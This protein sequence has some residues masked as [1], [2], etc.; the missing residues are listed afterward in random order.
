MLFAQPKTSLLHMREDSN[1]GSIEMVYQGSVNDVE[2]NSFKT[3]ATND[4]TQAQKEL[5]LKQRDDTELANQIKHELRIGE[6]PARDNTPSHSQPDI[7]SSKLTDMLNG[8]SPRTDSNGDFRVQFPSAVP[9]PL[10]RLHGS[11]VAVQP[12]LRG[13]TGASPAGP[14]TSPRT[15][16]T[17]DDHFYMTNEHLDVVGKTTYDALDMY[18]KQQISATNGKHEQLV[19]LVEK[20]IEGLKVQISSA[21]EKADHNSN[22]THN[23]AQKL[24]QLEKFFKDEVISAM[25]EQAKRAATLETDL[26]DVQKTMVLLQQAVEKLSE[27]KFEKQHP[28]TNSLS[29]PGASNP[30]SHAV[31]T[32]HSQPSLTSY[33]GHTN[34]TG[35]DDQPLMPSLQDRNVSNNY[36]SHSDQ[37]GSY[38][39]NWQPQAWNGRSSYQARSKD[40]RPSYSGTNPYHFTNGAQ[41][42]N[43]Y[44]ASYPSYNFSPSTPEQP[45]TYGQKPGQ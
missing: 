8:A 16:K 12:L 2:S 34:E 11:H 38:G 23:V 25:T 39:N 14:W 20:H 5:Q 26:N 10:T 7:S 40:D 45:Y 1:N 35:R 37:R 4:D 15:P 17:I 19:A 32:H 28:A 6:R 24:D 27:L 13:N 22:Q 18:S 41:Y 36:E 3:P 33:Y 44:M 31:P 21:N 9:S 42:N 29:T 43:G 30:V